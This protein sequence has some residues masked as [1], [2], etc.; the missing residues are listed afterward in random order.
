[1]HEGSITIHLDAQVPEVERLNRLICKFGELHEI[2]SRALYSLNLVLDELVTNVILYGYA[3]P[4]GKKVVVR[5]EL[6]AEQLTG[7]VE[8]RGCAFDPLAV[9]E[10]DLTA[11]LAERDLGGLGLPLVRSLMEEVSYCREG[12][13]NLLT[14]RKRIR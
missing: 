1:M 7:V 4:V 3:D 11:S 12:G 6:Q 5:I 8:D 10:P 14:V 13:K 9:P 2:P